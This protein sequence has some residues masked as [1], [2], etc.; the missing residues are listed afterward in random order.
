MVSQEVDQLDNAESN[1]WPSVMT[2]LMWMVHL[3]SVALVVWKVSSPT[4]PDWSTLIR[5]DGLSVIMM[6]VVSFIAAV[7]MSFSLRYMAGNQYLNDFF[8]KIVLFAFVVMLLSVTNHLLVFVVLWSAMGLIMG[9][10]IGHEEDWPQARAA[11]RLSLQYF[12]ASSAFLL[13]AVLV[14]YAE[15]GTITI[16]GALQK[17]SQLGPLAAFVIL[18]GLIVA[19]LIQSA[20]FPVQSWIM[21]S[22]TAPT[23]ASALM[24]AGFVNAGGILLTRF[25]PL[26]VSYRNVMLLI[27]LLGALSAIL[28]KIWKMAQPNIKRQLGCSTVAQMG[29]M[30][31]QCG[32][33]FFS[34]A[35]SH[36]ILHG[37]Y[38]GYLFLSSGATVERTVPKKSAAVRQYWIE[39]P[40]S[41]LTGLAG[42]WLFISLTGKGSKFNSGLLLTGLVV[43]TVMHATRELID[44]TRLPNWVRIVIFPLA[45]LTVTSLYAGIFLG[46]TSVMYD[47]PAVV[48]PTS[49]SWVHGVIGGFFLLAYLAVDLRLYTFSNQLYVA[50]LNAGQPHPA[51]VLSSKEEYHG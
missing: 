29:F 50:V 23:P 39:V 26:L 44:H 36:L 18:C 49:L 47:V 28:G 19:A 21:S 46:I 13:V 17:V 42:G 6:M 4:T 40:V 45:V 14:L 27:A 9:R 8:L 34:A 32:L 35:V 30:I 41:L 31:L 33:G 7:V 15:A 5:L 24:H 10:L 25:A 3:T 43:I 48:A 16:S 11:G 12:L 1:Y 51:T 20:L 38:K 2:V 22:M 37:F